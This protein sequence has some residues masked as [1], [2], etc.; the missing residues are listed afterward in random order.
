MISCVYV[1]F[2]VPCFLFALFVPGYGLVET[3]VEIVGGLIAKELAGLGDVG[4][5]VLD[6]TLA[7]GTEDGFDVDTEGVAERVVDVDEILAT[8]IG[9]VEGLAGGFGWR[10]ASTK[11]GLNHVVDIGEVAALATVSV[12]GGALALQQLLDEL[13]DD[14][15]IGAVRVLATAEHVEITQAVGVETVVERVLLRPFLVATLGEGVR[16]EKVAFNAFALGEMRLVAINGGT[17]GVNKLLHTT[18]TGCLK[19]VER[20]LDVV[21]AIEQ[22][23]LQR[24]GNTAPSGLVKNVVDSLAT[25]KAGVVIFDIAFDKLVASIVKEHVDIGLLA[26]A[27][28]VETTHAVAHGQKGFA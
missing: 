10:L 16:R 19:H 6:V 12:D 15:G 27:Q 9:D 26:G 18:A 7:V 8:A 17:G 14:G 23:L 25:A 28:V 11:I 5:G 4:V 2:I 1:V 24:A 21:G 3:V 22:R 13:G 20:A